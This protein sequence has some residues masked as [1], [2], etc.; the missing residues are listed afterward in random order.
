MEMY[1]LLSGSKAEVY[2]IVLDSLYYEVNQSSNKKINKSSLKKGFKHTKHQ[3]KGKHTVDYHYHLTE[4][5]PEKGYN[6]KVQTNS[7]TITMGMRF[8]SEEN[9]LCEVC[10]YEDFK[11]KVEEHGFLFKVSD[12][13]YQRKIKRRA[14]RMLK[15]IDQVIKNKHRDAAKAA[16]ED[17]AEENAS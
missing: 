12:F 8:E 10:Y 13:F 11:A 15:E 3:K 17:S 5:D 16:E 4:L 14:K 1:M 7:G 6:L 2:D 9:G